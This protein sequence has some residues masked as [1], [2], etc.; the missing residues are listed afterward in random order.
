MYDIT[1]PNENH[2]A[3]VGINDQ[4]EIAI[5]C[6][7]MQGNTNYIYHDGDLTLIGNLGVKSA[8]VNDINNNGQITGWLYIDDESGHSRR[9]FLATPVAL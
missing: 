9:A 4:E 2:C 5:K 3:A 8:T 1:P 6:T 7:G